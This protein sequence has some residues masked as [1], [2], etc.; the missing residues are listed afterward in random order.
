EACSTRINLGETSTT[1]RTAS[2]R[3]QAV[4][5]CIWHKSRAERQR[6]VKQGVLKPPW[7]QIKIRHLLSRTSRDTPVWSC[8]QVVLVSLD[9]SERIEPK[10]GW[11]TGVGLEGNHYIC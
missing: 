1:K 2:Q 3:P 9:A 7:L 11:H 4:H 8:R 10:T 6:R 5:S